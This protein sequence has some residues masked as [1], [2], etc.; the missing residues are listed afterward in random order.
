MIVGV[1]MRGRDLHSCAKNQGEAVARI[2]FQL[3][4]A[5]HQ[6]RRDK[7]LGTAIV[8]SAVVKGRIVLYLRPKKLGQVILR[9]GVPHHDAAQF[10]GIAR[11]QDGAQR[12]LHV[13]LPVAF[14]RAKRGRN[15]SRETSIL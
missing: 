6:S 2:V 13:E 5:D 9:H 11:R 4:L 14:A 1:E 8:R 7:V 3:D 12:R 10:R 15:R